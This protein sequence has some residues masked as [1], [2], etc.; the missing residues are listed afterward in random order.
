M[1]N[2]SFDFLGLNY[3]SYQS[4]MKN[5]SVHFMSLTRDIIY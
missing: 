1:F 4:N 2:S 5:S 3:Q